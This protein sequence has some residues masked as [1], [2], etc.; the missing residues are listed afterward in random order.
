MAIIIEQLQFVAKTTLN[1][2]YFTV[3]YFVLKGKL[4]FHNIY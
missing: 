3:T 4:I 1:H 2:K